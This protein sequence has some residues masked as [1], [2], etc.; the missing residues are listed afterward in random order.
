MIGEPVLAYQK[1]T[2]LIDFAAAIAAGLAL[3]YQSW[4]GVSP[5]LADPGLLTADNLKYA[6]LYVA[7]FALAALTVCLWR[8][9]SRRKIGWALIAVLGAG[10][11]T[12]V[13]EH[14]VARAFAREPMA[15]FAGHELTVLNFMLKCFTALLVM[16]AVHYGGLL[17][18]EARSR[19]PG[20]YR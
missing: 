20:R 12:G 18:R 1:D 9:R 17:L 10:F 14:L 6:S 3:Q 4:S 5:L 11:C 2:K 7:A 15:L 8:G 16:G 13:Q 19:P